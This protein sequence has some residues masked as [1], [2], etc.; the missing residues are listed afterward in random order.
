MQKIYNY[1]DTLPDLTI[2]IAL[3]CIGGIFWL[4]KAIFSDE[5]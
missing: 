1:I 3:L 5:E 2:F 4:L